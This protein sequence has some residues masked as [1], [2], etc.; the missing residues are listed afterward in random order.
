MGNFRRV[1]EWAG[2]P[3]LVRLSGGDVLSSEDV[4][5][6]L[7][8]RSVKGVG[9][10]LS[11]TARTLRRSGIR[12]EEAALRKTV[13]GRVQ[14]SAGPRIR[15]A[16]HVLDQERF[17][18]TEVGSDR[19]LL[20]TDEPAGP[21]LVLRALKSRGDFYR[22]DGGLAGLSEIM[23][24]DGYEYSDVEGVSIGEIFVHRIEAGEDGR[25][26]PVPAGYG[27]NGIW[28]RGDYDYDDPR[29][30]GAIGSGIF[31]SLIAWIGEATWV[32]RRL[33]LGDAERQVALARAE[34]R[35][36]LSSEAITRWRDVEPE[37]RFEYVRWVG[38]DGPRR[39]YRA[40]PVH[41]RLRCWYEVVISTAAGK[42]IVLREEGLRGD[43]ARTTSRAIAK[44][45]RGHGRG[46]GE[47]V[48]VQ[49]FRIARK[50][51]RPM[52]ADS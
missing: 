2:L 48:T 29:V 3:L 11:G 28:V 20:P 15:Q 4:R 32:E 47:P 5:A 42:R 8:A 37:T 19:K 40:P 14:W 44:W 52:P 38:T 24:Y 7:G 34:D 31:A 9:V 33:P 41:L 26:G 21:A 23:S 30:P 49:E 36:S 46:A 39:S 45:R 12:M 17:Q 35:W 6:L 16:V 1:H 43:D 50:Q 18:W 25:A 27:E 22:I 10:A 13:R 51:S